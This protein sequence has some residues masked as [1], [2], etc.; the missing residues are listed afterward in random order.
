M[1][2]IERLI[3]AIIGGGFLAATTVAAS[4]GTVAAQA[5]SG[6]I[7]LILAAAPDVI[8][9]LA[10]R[11]VLDGT[12]VTAT[13]CTPPTAVDSGVETRCTGLPD[14]VYDVGV[15]GADGLKVQHRC[16]DI[17][18]AVADRPI[19]D[20]DGGFWSWVCWIDA[21]EPAV[22]ID[23]GAGMSPPLPAGV[24]IDL[25]PPEGATLDCV[26]DSFNG[27]STQRCRVSALGTVTPVVTGVEPG[28]VSHVMCYPAIDGGGDLPVAEV[29]DEN[30]LWV[31]GLSAV[32]PTV[33]IWVQASVDDVPVD[34]APEAIT[35]TGPDPDA[36][37]TC[38]AT[39]WEGYVELGCP[40][41]V[42]GDYTVEIAGLP[43]PALGNELSQVEQCTQFTLPASPTQTV[44]CPTTMWL[45]TGAVPATTEP[46]PT[47][48]VLPP[49]N[50][51][52]PSTG[53]SSPWLA[54]AAGVLVAL[55]AGLVVGTRRPARSGR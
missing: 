19:I 28:Y 18:A 32:D 33:S 9:G 46:A 8:G 1:R 35:I 15:T 38:T 34:I 43:D 14:G 29:T 50:G 13:Y 22:I 31:C 40:L 3:I 55:G 23:S 53:N 26:D 20:L 21:G 54:I 45:Y 5:T 47:S 11:L 37:A 41:T 10:P 36:R 2:R 44:S 27:G 4:T 12:D 48:V 24:G 52:L 51:L 16:R 7:D 25:V 30:W 42:A 6:D 39:T 17:V 49:E